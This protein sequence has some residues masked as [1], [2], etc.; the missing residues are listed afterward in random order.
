MMIKKGTSTDKR[1]S[2]PVGLLIHA[3]DEASGR[4]ADTPMTQPLGKA[5]TTHDPVRRPLRNRD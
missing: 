4:L 1:L 3:V 5:V 2:C